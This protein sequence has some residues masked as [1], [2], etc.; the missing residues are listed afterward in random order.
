MRNAKKI[1]VERSQA[2]KLS[3]TMKA[4]IRQSA[5]L[6]TATVNKIREVA[7]HIEANSNRHL[8]LVRGPHDRNV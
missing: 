8:H 6:V 1:E 2:Q 4:H 3:D 5:D 7:D